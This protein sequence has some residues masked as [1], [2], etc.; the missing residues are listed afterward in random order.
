[1]KQYGKL[2]KETLI[3]TERWS[4]GDTHKPNQSKGKIFSPTKEKGVGKINQNQKNSPKTMIE[5][6]KN[7]Q[8]LHQFLIDYTGINKT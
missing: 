4:Y 7:S 2:R 5:K 1:M 6:D 3:T 8:S